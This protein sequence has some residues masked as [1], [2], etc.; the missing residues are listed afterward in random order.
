M[1]G[2]S[3]KSFNAPAFENFPP[4]AAVLA[5][6]VGFS[7]S[8]ALE[9]SAYSNLSLSLTDAL[10]SGVFVP[11]QEGFLRGYDGGDTQYQD[12]TGIT[13]STRLPSDDIVREINFF[14]GLTGLDGQG[15]PGADENTDQT[16]II[17]PWSREDV[18]E[19]LRSPVTFVAQLS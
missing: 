4:E 13:Y 2:L 18:T 12:A 14:E 5:A 16:K 15:A 9:A 8:Y 6:L 10:G 3:A 17:N 11:V 19:L 7:N 1:E